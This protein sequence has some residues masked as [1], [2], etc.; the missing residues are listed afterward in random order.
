MYGQAWCNLVDF[1]L[2]WSIHRQRNKI[3]YY[4]LF[5]L[6][7]EF[8]LGMYK[9]TDKQKISVYRVVAQL[10]ISTKSSKAWHSLFDPLFSG[11]EAMLC[12]NS[13][14]GSISGY[15]TYNL[16]QLL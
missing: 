15:Y 14:L 3:N 7:C 5:Y 9:Q 11:L 4:F 10:K 1:D 2:V 8:V 12:H 13:F 16:V 6:I